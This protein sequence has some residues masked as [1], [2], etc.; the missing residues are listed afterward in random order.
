LTDW[1]AEAASGVVIV[2]AIVGFARWALKARWRRQLRVKIE[3]LLAGK[4]RQ[5][6]D[7]LMVSQLS[8][9]LGVSE[10]AIIEAANGSKKVA[11]WSGQL[12]NERRYRTIRNSN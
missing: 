6:D 3:T 11:P 10:D 4:T 9:H 8:T 1:L 12:G 5:N 7:S 2:G